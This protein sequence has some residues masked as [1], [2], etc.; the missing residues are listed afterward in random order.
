MYEKMNCYCDSN[1][2]EK[3]KSVADAEARITELTSLIEEM[4]AKSSTL[5]TEIATLKEEFEENNAALGKATD[6]RNKENA[7]FQEDEANMNEG[8]EGLRGAVGV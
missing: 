6:I 5:S 2:K 8:I 3:S 4:T 7:E 1:K